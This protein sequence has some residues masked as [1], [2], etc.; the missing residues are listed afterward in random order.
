MN[1]RTEEINPVQKQ[2]SQKLAEISILLTS[3]NSIFSNF[4]P[5]A[6]AEKTLS[7]DFITQAKKIPQNKK[8]K[9]MS[10]RLLLPA[11][12]RNEQEEKV[13]VTRLHSYFNSVHQQLKFC[14]RKTNKTGL[15]YLNDCSKLS[16]FY[17]AGKI[18]YAFTACVV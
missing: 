14:V 8:G 17:E 2:S 11:N 3:Y 1:K 15:S 9:K 6:Y 16:L 13:I 7:D 5:N 12:K 10:L 18:P 4:D